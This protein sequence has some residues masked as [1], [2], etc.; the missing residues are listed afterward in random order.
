MSYSKISL[1]GH[2]KTA[3][4]TESA[5]KAFIYCMLGLL[6]PSRCAASRAMAAYNAVYAVCAAVFG[7]GYGWAATTLLA[8]FSASGSAGTPLLV[9]ICAMQLV[10]VWTALRDRACAQKLSDAVATAL[11]ATPPRL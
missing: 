6:Y 2:P 9:L 8:R 4:I 3:G 1:F 11:T 10:G 5:P 7:W